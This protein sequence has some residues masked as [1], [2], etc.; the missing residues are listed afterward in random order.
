M[1]T[2]CPRC[3]SVYADDA[4][5]CP[6]DGTKLETMVSAPP[7]A[8]TPLARPFIPPAPPAPAAP[9]TPP[10][11]PPAAPSAPP[12]P[13]SHVR[14]FEPLGSEN[15][16]TTQRT[17]A[18]TPVPG[19]PA[20]YSKLVGETLDSRYSITRKIGEGGMSFV[21]LADD[22]IRKEQVAIKI[23][24]PALSHDRTAMARLRREAE[25]AGRLVH[26]NVCHI[27]RL[28]ETSNGLVYVVMPFVQGE[29]LC[30]VTNRAKQLPLEQTVRYITDIAA[31]L[32]V[33]H[34]LGIVHRD[35]KPENIMISRNVD[36]TERAIVM[37]FGLAKERQV[38]DEIKK[39]TATG[40][41]LGTPEFMSPEQLRGKPLD[42]RTD[43]YSLGLMAYE[44]LTGK[45]PFIGRTQQEIMIARL[46]SE[47]QPIRASRPD[48]N[49]S[50]G[51]E[52]VLLKSTE[53]EPAERYQTAPEFAAA[54]GEAAGPAKGNSGVLDRIFG[55]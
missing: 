32:Q 45:L 4:R 26:P 20:D 41:V 44:M 22:V 18:Q 11:T 7:P 30:D 12:P 6:K 15:R 33:A 50:A 35:L 49:F 10:P 21:Y 36:G 37:D 28:G 5:F 19:K 13:A 9:P 46:R 38:S 52:K 16:A 40:I 27:I 24:S 47:P 31:G 55:R 2:R 42:P 54:L 29:L 23:L 51:L 48:L 1:S 34:D 43:V 3:Q 53:R 39:L 17:G 25:L 14:V 8:P